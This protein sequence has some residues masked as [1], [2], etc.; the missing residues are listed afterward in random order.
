MKKQTKKRW[1]IALFVVFSI[2]LMAIVPIEV[3]RIIKYDD[4]WTSW[5]IVGVVIYNEI[6]LG[7]HLYKKYKK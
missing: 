6:A 1:E 3:Y 5:L 4:I 2:L 7:I